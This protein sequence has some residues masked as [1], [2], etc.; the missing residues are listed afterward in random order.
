MIGRTQRVLPN[1]LLG[2]SR[3][4]HLIEGAGIDVGWPGRLV[5]Y[6]RGCERPYRH[7]GALN[8]PL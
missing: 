8:F 6:R 4:P 1:Q 3:Y 7:S 2:Y 5:D